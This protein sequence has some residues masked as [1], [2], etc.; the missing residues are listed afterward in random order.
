[1]NG[2]ERLTELYDEENAE[3]VDIP[4]ELYKINHPREGYDDETVLVRFLHP[5][6]DLDE[7][8]TEDNRA[9]EML[10]YDKE[11]PNQWNIQLF[12]AYHEE[13]EIDD[14]TRSE[15]ESNTRFAIRRCIPVDSLGAFLRPLE[16]VREDL[17]AIDL[18][19]ERGNLIQEII[20]ADL[21]FL[22]DL[23]STSREERLEKLK[24][25]DN[26]SSER[27]AEGP[28]E[29]YRGIIDSIELDPEFRTSAKQRALD[30]KPFTLL[31]GRNGS[32]KTSLLDGATLGMVGQIRGKNTLRSHH[33]DDL[34]VTLT[35]GENGPITLS[36]EPSDVADRI[37]AWYGFRP[38]GK[39]HRHTEFYHV[40]Y[41]E[42]G[43]TT[44]LADPDANI[45]LEQTIR[46]SLY[47]EKLYE[48]RNEKRELVT[49][50]RKRVEK[51][52]KEIAELEAELAEL[53]EDLERAESL[54][55]TARTAQDELSPAMQ[56]VIP[57]P[58]SQQRLQNSEADAEHD[59]WVR[60]WT[61]WSD[62]LQRLHESLDIAGISDEGVT[63]PAEL[64][65][66]LD[67]EVER[68]ETAIIQLEDIE[69][70]QREQTGL[71]Q[72]YDDLESAG[73]GESPPTEAF[74]ATI[75]SLHGFE[76]E[77][78]RC[79][80][81]AIDEEEPKTEETLDEWRTR[82]KKSFENRLAGLTE[83]REAIREITDLQAKREE[84]LDEI[85]ARTEE[86]LDITEKVEYCP[87]CYVEQT[88]E[89]IRDREQP[90]DLLQS[91]SGVPHQLET[92]IESLEDAIDILARSSWSD[93]AD[94]LETRFS[95][96]GGTEDYWQVWQKVV[97][98]DGTVLPRS[99]EGHVT[100]FAEAIRG[101]ISQADRGETTAATLG[102]AYH[103]L[104][105]E[106]TS[107]EG[108]VEDFDLSIDDVA[109]AIDRLEERRD[110]LAA[111]IQILEE[112]IPITLQQDEFNVVHDRQVI[113]STKS[114]L[115][116]DTVV[117]ESVA[118]INEDIKSTRRDLQMYEA[119]KQRYEDGI[120]RLNTVF[121][122]AGGDEELTAYVREHMAAITTLFQAFQRPYQFER[123][124][125]DDNDEVR[126]I[127]R[128][129]EEPEPISD[130]SSGQRAAL[131]LAIFVTNNLTHGH[132]PPVLL[133]DEPFAHL[134]DINTISFFNLL[135]ELATRGS[136]EQNHQVIFATA[137]KD[138][139][140]LLKR[141]IGDSPKFRRVLVDE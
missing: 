131:A 133:L 68:T 66:A 80:A 13:V 86:Y 45:D 99:T 128:D 112:H 58:P 27:V 84:L 33:Y 114:E 35:G 124:L 135:I 129:G 65:T 28:V 62:R 109:Q 43:S 25:G 3:Q 12:W 52:E 96:I 76:V 136:D 42:S 82:L 30:A 98:V 72:L 1:M 102:D 26:S 94:E 46:R 44:R 81:E 103:A 36:N 24:E 49:E 23:D 127:R 22:F 132:A 7:L 60:T 40:N 93:L 85:Q 29:P 48:A 14:T 6:D 107:L 71:E 70:L 20:E 53:E 117:V 104:D 78:F 101:N 137:N 41:H 120:D 97:T 31:F 9:L 138:I 4:G 141:K 16:T 69:E 8:R 59:E 21:G 139:A 111:G 63:T 119:E 88:E 106:V 113:Q 18:G 108:S 140:D 50:A 100:R 95:D 77:D 32:G 75:F 125:L 126:V 121:E 64:S 19:F 34:K 10:F 115:Q 130:M 79:I 91:N 5:D 90:T 118:Q 54:F 51:E 134:D 15:F 83:K 67:R 17:G 47:G 87:A 89:A 37:S 11:T 105:D 110:Q 116:K 61:T 55:S 2:Y 57:E 74:V 123:V 38:V 122:R 73:W 56:A 92:K 39:Q